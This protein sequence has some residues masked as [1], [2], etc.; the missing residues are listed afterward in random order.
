[1]PI[2]PFCHANC[3]GALACGNLPYYNKGRSK[4]ALPDGM[5][6]TRA[7]RGAYKTEQ[8]SKI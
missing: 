1:M 8:R 7:K 5:S 6:T 3:K 2:I 4:T